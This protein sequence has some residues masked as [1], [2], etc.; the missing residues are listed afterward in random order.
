MRFYNCI[1]AYDTMMSFYDPPVD[2]PMAN[3][4]LRARA[5]MSGCS[6]ARDTS[7]TT[8]CQMAVRQ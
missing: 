5:G 4:S 1:Y 7:Q 2:L 6:S 3:V 8:A